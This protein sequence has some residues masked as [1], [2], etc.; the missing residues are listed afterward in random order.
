[1][2]P[3]RDENPART[4]PYVVYVL[5]AVNVL[6]YLYNGALRPSGNP[7]SGLELVPFELTRGTDIGAPTPVAPWVTIFT[8]MFLHANLLHIAGNMLYLWIFGN[9]IEDVLGHV[10]FLFFYL[11]AGAAAAMTQVLFALSSTVPTVGASGA[12]AGVLGAY[13]VLY[14]RARVITLILIF[15]FIQV[16]AVSAALVLG[17]WIALQVVSSLVSAASGLSGSGG[18]AYGA[19]VGGFAAGAALI[20]ILGGR[21]LLR[22]RRAIPM[23]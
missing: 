18:V 1:M 13:I 15:P 22:G 5:I 21:R 19:H 16:T 4:I 9:N 17:L 12:I 2:I 6:V 7:L 11:L 14:P 10:K 20:L 3:L 8:S 23:A